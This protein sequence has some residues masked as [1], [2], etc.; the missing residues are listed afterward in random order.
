M[1]RPVLRGETCPFWQCGAM[2]ATRSSPTL[3]KY[4]GAA[5]VL[6]LA[7]LSS[8]ATLLVKGSEGHKSRPVDHHAAG[9]HISGDNNAT[10]VESPQVLKVVIF[11]HTCPSHSMLLHRNINLRTVRL[12]S[13]YLWNSSS[14]VYAW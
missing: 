6:A 9:H 11:G 3:S 12:R 4:A 5:V 13:H 1:H 10:T 14:C 7:A 8:T 2:A